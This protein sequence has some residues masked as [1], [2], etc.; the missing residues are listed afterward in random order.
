[1]LS[2]KQHHSFPIASFVAS[3][4]LKHRRHVQQAWHCI[5]TAARRLVIE[6]KGLYEL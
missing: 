6:C 1:M 4:F 5:K 3:P 2:F